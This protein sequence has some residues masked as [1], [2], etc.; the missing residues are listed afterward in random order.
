MLPSATSRPRF[1]STMFGVSDCTSCST[2]LETTTVLPC[3]PSWRDDVH[4]VAAGHGIGAGERFVQE[5][6]QRIVH[7]GLGELGPL[8]HALGVAAH[9][10][11]GV[12][13]VM[14]TMAR[15]LFGGGLGLA[16][17]HAGQAGAGEDEVPAGHPFVEG[18]LLRDTG[19]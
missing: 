2:W 10:A 14:A 5:K 1:I 17:A 9:L 3:L 15:A 8:P 13:S 19:R 16:S 6:H 7:Q 18:V 12:C 4:Q 11:V